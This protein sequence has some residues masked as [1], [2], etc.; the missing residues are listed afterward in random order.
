M[1]DVAN[2]S[3]LA[4]ALPAEERPSLLLNQLLPQLQRLCPPP[5]GYTPPPSGICA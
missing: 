4:D 3:S 2:L 1:S 5:L